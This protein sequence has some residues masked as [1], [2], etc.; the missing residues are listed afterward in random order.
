MGILYSL[1][2]RDSKSLKDFIERFNI[3]IARIRNLN[4]EVALYAFSQVLKLGPF[5]KYLDISPM[6]TLDELC[7]RATSYIRVE[8][9]AENRKR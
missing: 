2:Q 7:T 5:A 1:N 9:G 3:E 6:E 8:E 4:Q